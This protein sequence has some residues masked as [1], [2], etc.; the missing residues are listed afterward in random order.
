MIW[1]LIGAALLAVLLLFARWYVN[2]E[3]RDVVSVLRYIGLFFAL[4]VIGVA[5]MSG[6]FSILWLILLSV[7]PW[8]GRLRAFNRQVD[9]LRGPASGQHI[10]KRTKFVVLYVNQETG[11]MD[12]RVLMG[13]KAG[14]LLSE[15]GIDAL[16]TL[17]ESAVIEDHESAEIIQAYLDRMHSQTWRSKSKVFEGRSFSAEENIGGGDGMTRSDAYE[18]LGLQPGASKTEIECTSQALIELGHPDESE[19]ED[20]RRK[21]MQAKGILL[22]E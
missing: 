17:Y 21:V 13:P 22:G 2:A 15:L 3:P 14:M 16:V 10:D 18:I 8:L 7:L 4:V 11:D 20:I 12:G 1:I 6:R 19:A 9:K 5:V